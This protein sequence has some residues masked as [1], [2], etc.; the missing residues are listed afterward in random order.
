MNL[1]RQA[2]DPFRRGK[3]R[4]RLH[5]ER[6]QARLSGGQDRLHVHVR[7]GLLPHV[8]VRRPLRDAL[9]GAALERLLLQLQILRQPLHERHTARDLYARRA[10]RADDRILPP[11]LYRRA[12]PLLRRA[13]LAGLYDGVDDPR[14]VDFAQ[15]VP[16]QR[17]HPRQGYPR[18]VAGA[19]R[20]ARLSF[21]PPE[22]E[23]RAAERSRTQAA[24]PQ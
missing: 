4:R 7:R 11:Q 6:G 13:A 24:R 3:V 21:R 1:L 12:V 9:E 16:L 22:R 19:C 14:A 8:F 5:L 18:H 2:H 20:T 15:R 10:C 23:H 17:L